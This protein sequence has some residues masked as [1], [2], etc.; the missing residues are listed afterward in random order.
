M[1]NI[2]NNTDSVIQVLIN[3]ICLFINLTNVLCLP[4]DNVTDPFQ[5]DVM[6]L[7]AEAL[8]F[9]NISITFIPY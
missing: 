9:K 1:P 2:K 4:F 5:S 6:Y 3:Y 7:L 8:K